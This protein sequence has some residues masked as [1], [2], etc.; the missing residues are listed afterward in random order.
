MNS[1]MQ[2]P[3]KTQ[4]EHDKEWLERREPRR[5]MKEIKPKDEQSDKLSLEILEYWNSKG[6][7]VHRNY[8]KKTPLILTRITKEFSK[9][10]IFQSIDNYSRVY[11]DDEYY[12]NYKW[13][14]ETFLQKSNTLPAFIDDGSKWLSYLE[15]MVPKAKKKKELPLPVIEH[16]K[17]IIIA[18]EDFHFIEESYFSDNR[19]V[20]PYAILRI[21]SDKPLA[22]L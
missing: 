4:D 20:Q 22:T 17:E 21:S 7:I 9:E 12:F 8:T 16:R 14:L 5:E 10:E 6:I 1:T 18:S 2:K 11:H 19:C 15:V 3:K 13:D